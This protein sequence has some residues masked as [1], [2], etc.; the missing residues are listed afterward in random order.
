[1]N[2]VSALISATVLVDSSRQAHTQ[3][4]LTAT[5]WK[6]TQPS[7]C[8]CSRTFVKANESV[9]LPCQDNPHL[10][11]ESTLLKT[12][13]NQEERKLVDKRPAS[14]PLSGQFQPV[15]CFSR[16]PCRIHRRT[17]HIHPY[18]AP[19]FPFLT[20]RNLSLL[21]YAIAS[22]INYL[23]PFSH[24][25]FCFLGNLNEDRISPLCF[26]QK[27]FVLLFLVISSFSLLQAYK[28]DGGKMRVLVFSKFHIHP[29][30]FIL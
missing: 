12:T 2:P 23:H 8:F 6:C 15:F 13:L 7:F 1:M 22:Q 11:R 10:R 3:L 17:L 24:S 16:R 29:V 4:V 18:M 27:K 9:W 25:R 21:I 26:C 28:L 5:P 14:C 30:A 20:L 19:H